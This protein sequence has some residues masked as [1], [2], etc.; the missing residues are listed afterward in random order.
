MKSLSRRL[1]L[2]L[3]LGALAACP[4]WAQ[5]QSTFPDKPIRMVLPF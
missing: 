2:T 3:G 1:A 5:A 4:A